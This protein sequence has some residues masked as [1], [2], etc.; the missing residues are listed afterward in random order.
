MTRQL[1]NRARRAK[2]S[3]IHVL[4]VVVAVSAGLLAWHFLSEAFV[5]VRLLLSSPLQ[6]AGYGRSHFPELLT[7]AA[8]TSYESLV[9]LLVGAVLACALIQATIAVPR[10]LDMIM[11]AGQ[12]SQALPLISLAPFFIVALG[13]GIA[14]KVAMT[15]LVSF[16]PLLMGLAGALRSLPTDLSSYLAFRNVR[17]TRVFWLVTVRLRLP[18][19]LRAA[20]LA[21][22]LSVIGAIVA[23]FNGAAQGLGRN[24]FLAAKRL[25][26]EMMVL[27]ILLAVGLSL[28]YYSL[29]GIVDRNVN[30]WFWEAVGEP[31]QRR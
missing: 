1:T 6:V 18:D 11:T 7:D 14:S 22:S 21:A 8:V 25:E 19:L 3:P 9:G 31:D 13:L 26:P 24:L 27:S 5:P 17:P 20:R 29:L 16:F 30:S 28:A 4:T 15:V 23:E 2:R 10:T 12:L